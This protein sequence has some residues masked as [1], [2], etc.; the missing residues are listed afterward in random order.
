[1]TQLFL[2]LLNM[3]ITASWIVLAVMLL[4]MLLRKAPKWITCILWSVVALRLILPVSVESIVSLVPSPEVIPQDII[5]LETPAIHSAIPVVNS[6]VNP[7]FTGYL[8]PEVN[9]LEKGLSIATIIWAVG[10]GIMLLYSLIT[11]LRIWWQVQSSIRQEKNVYICDDVDSPFILGTIAPKIYMP[12]GMEESQQAYVLAHEHAHIKRGDHWWKPLG[13]LLLTVYWFNPLL[14][15]A[16]ILLCRDIE[17]ACDEKVIAGM[18]SDGKRG[19]SEA[20]VACSL[21][22]RMVMVCPLAFGEVSVK[23]RIKGVL[24]YKKPAVWVALA[25][26]LVCILTA[27]CFLTDP[28]PCAHQYE[29]EVV[30]EATC[31]SRGVEKRTCSLCQHI[32]TAYIDM[33]E[34]SYGESVVTLAATCTQPGSAQQTCTQCG[35]TKTEDVA[36]APHTAGGTIFTQEANCTQE[37]KQ[38]ATCVDCAQTFVMQ[39]LPV[40]GV[41]DMEETV[42]RA[43]TCTEDGEGAKT[44]TRCG[45]SESISYEATGHKYGMGIFEITDCEEDSIIRYEC[46]TCGHEK[47]TV[48]PA[49]GHSWSPSWQGTK[50]CIRCHKTKTDDSYSSGYSLLDGVSGG[51]TNK[52]QPG[53]IPT[54]QI[55]P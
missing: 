49:K 24:S 43:V 1:M 51:S 22:R 13:F 34:H 39:V 36:L 11:Y 42:L 16:Y 9:L 25:A 12:S 53:Y 26:L 48:Q 33:R 37:G 38:V 15:V 46:S 3:S 17:M 7:L 14:W 30:M 20:L 28:L 40:N 10:V 23:S 8:T 29:S 21:H 50:W 5:Q 55:W 52:Y 6:T 32:Y 19:Y 47:Q 4:R 54:I 27:G 31:T 41:H 44:C 2:K 45:Y 18:D 35:A